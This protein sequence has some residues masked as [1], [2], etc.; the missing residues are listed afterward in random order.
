MPAF[1][2]AHEQD[3]W[4]SFVEDVLSAQECNL[5]APQALVSGERQPRLHHRRS[6]CQR[7]AEV[8]VADRAGN[9]AGKFRAS[10]AGR[11]VVRT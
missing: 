3:G 4:P 10:Y 5:L 1:A 2:L 8:L 7:V 6:D 11:G 9:E